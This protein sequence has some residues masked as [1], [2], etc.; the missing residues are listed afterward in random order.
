MGRKVWEKSEC[1]WW[2][3]DEIRDEGK[4]GKLVKGTQ[5]EIITHTLSSWSISRSSP[6]RSPLIFDSFQFVQ[7]LFYA[8]GLRVCTC[9]YLFLCSNNVVSFIFIFPPANTDVQ[10]NQSTQSDV[11]ISFRHT[12]LLLNEKQ[13]KENGSCGWKWWFSKL[14]FKKDSS[15]ILSFKDLIH[16]CAQTSVVSYLGH[17]ITQNPSRASLTVLFSFLIRDLS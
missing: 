15:L 6:L 1:E 3:D 13:V 11:H 8:Q 4:K 17:L 7:L 9:T 16:F 14:H 2:M 10:C 12:Q 5:G